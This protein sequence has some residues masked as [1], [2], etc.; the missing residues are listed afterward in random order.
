VICD[1]KAATPTQPPE[2]VFATTERSEFDS[3]AGGVRV[4]RPA[5][6]LPDKAVRPASFRGYGLLG[7]KDPNSGLGTTENSRVLFSSSYPG[8]CGTHAARKVPGR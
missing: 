2:L 7:A 4:V 8:P 5:C 3:P 6:A 1:A